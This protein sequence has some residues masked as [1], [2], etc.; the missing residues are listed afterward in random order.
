MFGQVNYD[1]GTYSQLG[2]TYLKYIK[3]KYLTNNPNLMQPFGETYKQ[4]LYY[5]LVSVS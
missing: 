1:G 2:H 4:D 3:N 5:S